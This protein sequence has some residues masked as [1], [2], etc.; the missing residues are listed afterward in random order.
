MVKFLH[1]KGKAGHILLQ[2]T[3]LIFCF[4]FRLFSPQSFKNHD[5][6]FP[7]KTMESPESI[8]AKL[9]LRS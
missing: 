5:M 2:H 8:I 3:V 1:Q 4:D 7:T 9:I 6:R